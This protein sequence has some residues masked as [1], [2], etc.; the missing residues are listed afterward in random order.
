MA[1]TGRKTTRRKTE[2]P[3][4]RTVDP[5]VPFEEVLTDAAASA[6]DEAQIRDRAHEIWLE[7][8]RPDG[9]AAEHWRQA[10]KELRSRAG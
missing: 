6:V 7:E 2:A 3:D 4:T 1:I 8:G 9:Q 10:E 5:E